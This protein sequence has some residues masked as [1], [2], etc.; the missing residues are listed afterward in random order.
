MEISQYESVKLNPTS[1]QTIIDVSNGDMRKAIMML[2]NLKFLY[3][4]KKNN[5][6]TLQSMSM[7]ELRYV[8]NLVN[9]VPEEITEND[10]YDV[11]ASIPM[12]VAFNII[13]K[14]IACKSIV[15]ITQLARKIIALGYP[16]DNILGQLNRAVLETKKFDDNI[17]A[18]II[19]YSGRIF[20]K[21]K[22]CGNEYIQLCDYLSSIYN[23]TK[24]ID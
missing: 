22:E 12:N 4:Y 23:N 5:H 14:T 20:L 2:Q 6:K 7:Q 17:R 11:A 9:S 1:V 8:R 21:M 18:K 16:I 10:I 24:T 3:E 19:I 13:D 15:E